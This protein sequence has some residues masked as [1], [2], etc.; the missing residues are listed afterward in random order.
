MEPP[1]GFD[2]LSLPPP[3]PGVYIIFDGH[4]QRRVRWR[5]GYRWRGH[6]CSWS[7]LRGYPPIAPQPIAYRANDPQWG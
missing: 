1:R 3:E 7:S 5:P 6:D 4:W 2:W